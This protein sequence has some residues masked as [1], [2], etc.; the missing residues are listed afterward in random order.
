MIY[1][2]NGQ[3]Y[4][5][6][7][8]TFMAQSHF[9]GVD[10]LPAIIHDKVRQFCIF[11]LAWIKWSARQSSTKRFIVHCRTLSNLVIYTQK[12]S[13]EIFKTIKFVSKWPLANVSQAYLHKRFFLAT[14]FIA[15]KVRQCTIKKICRSLSRSPFNSIQKNTKIVAP[16]RGLVTYRG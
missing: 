3:L 12:F 13:F 9:Y 14:N 11:F 16:C 15:D 2:R 10:N 7:N 6:P 1:L 5:N 8:L 4:D